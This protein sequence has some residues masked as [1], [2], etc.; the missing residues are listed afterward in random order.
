MFTFFVIERNPDIANNAI[1]TIESICK[2]IKRLNGSDIGYISPNGVILKNAN[3]RNNADYTS[4]VEGD[5]LSANITELVK[6]NGPVIFVIGL[7]LSNKEAIAKDKDEDID[8]SSLIA[9]IIANNL[10]RKRDCAFLFTSDNTSFNGDFVEG[11]ISSGE[12]TSDRM[13]HTKPFKSVG[14]Y[15]EDTM[16]VRISE[17]MAYLLQVVAK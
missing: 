9:A 12:I 5:K 8:Y 10:Q 15:D 14:G 16:Q 11:L 2:N 4:T 17:L 3:A 1:D 13:T 7:T 6:T